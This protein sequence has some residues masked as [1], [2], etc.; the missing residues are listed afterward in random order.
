M[1]T[2]IEIML[3]QLGQQIGVRFEVIYTYKRS[4]FRGK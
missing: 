1:F 4:T 2:I 3:T